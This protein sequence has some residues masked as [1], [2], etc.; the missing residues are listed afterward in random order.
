MRNFFLR[1]LLWLQFTGSLLALV[2]ILLNEAN[3]VAPQAYGSTPDVLGA[4]ITLAS[5]S[6]H[7]N[8]MSVSIDPAD[9]R[10]ELVRLFMLKYQQSS[11]M[12][13]Y[14]DQ[15]VANAD[16]NGID[17]RLVPAIAMCESN[18]GVRIPSKDSYNA[19]GIAVY[20]GEKSG[21]KFQNWSDAIS[22]VSQYI[23]SSYYSRGITDL[24]QI[25]AI[26]APPSVNTGHSWANCVKQY[27]EAI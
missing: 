17:Y 3:P 11:P 13:P 1:S 24:K 5:S 26:W 6:D 9:A 10:S 19:W 27:Q 8:A 25:G 7:T 15:I 4:Q 14:T 16:A 12:L 20:T 21:R 23:S 18:L 22:W 2:L